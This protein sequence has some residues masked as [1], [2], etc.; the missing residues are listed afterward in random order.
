MA[1]TIK[2]ELTVADDD[3]RVFVRTLEGEDAEKWQKFVATVCL[4]AHVHNAN[5]DWESLPWHKKEVGTYADDFDQL[6]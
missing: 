4:L 3:G 5:P 6:A 1:K 2:V